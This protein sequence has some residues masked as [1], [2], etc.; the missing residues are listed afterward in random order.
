M[1]LQLNRP[2][3]R[4][5]AGSAAALGIA[6]RREV[7]TSFLPPAAAAYQT[8]QPRAPKAATRAARYLQRSDCSRSG[9]S[10]LSQP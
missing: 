5:C 7:V 9:T 1:R 3:L 2:R 10:R 6:T 4:V 8:P